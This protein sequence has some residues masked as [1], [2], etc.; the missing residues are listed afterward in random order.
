VI[1][2]GLYYKPGSLKAR[3]CIEGRRALLD[4]CEAEDI[5]H[6]TCGKVVV[7]TRPGEMPALEML[8]ERGRANG[9]GGCGG[10]K[11]KKSAI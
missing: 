7:A 5:P 4:F 8:T 9:L 1:H 11:P 10:W 3:L 2:S 6:E